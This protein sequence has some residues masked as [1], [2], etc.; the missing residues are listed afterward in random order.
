L[1]LG[2]P[3]GN[4][5]VYV[6]DEQQREVPLGVVGEICIGGAGVSRGYLHEGGVTAAQYVPDPFSASGGERLYRSGDQGRYLADGRL[7]FVG[8]GDGQVKVRGY[9]VELG[10]VE[11]ALRT[12]ESV[13]ESVVVARTETDAEQRLVAYLVGKPGQTLTNAEVRKS[14]GDKLPPYMIPSVFV[15]LDNLPLT[16]NGKVNRHA[17]P[18]P[19]PQR[20][21]SDEI[22]VTARN[23]IEETLASI[24]AELLRI[25]KVGIHDNFFELGGDSIISMQIVA[26]ANR[27]GLRLRPAQL[28]QYQTIA[29]LAAVAGDRST[30]LEQLPV[31][32]VV[33]LTPIQHWFFEQDLPNPHHWNQSVLL[34]VRQA[35]APSLLQRAVGHVLVH[36]DALRM[37]FHRGETGWKQINAPAVAEIPFSLVDLSK[38][39][40]EEQTAA[41]NAAA[42]EAQA[43]LNLVTGPLLRAVYF[44]LGPDRHGLLLLVIHHLVVDG[45]SWRILLEDLEL[46]YLQMSRGEM[47]SLSPKT[48]SFKT[49]ASQLTEPARGSNVEQQIDYWAT[50]SERQASDLPVDFHGQTNTQASAR[51]VTVALTVAETRALLHEVSVRHHTH[52]NEVLLAALVHSFSSFTENP[53]LLIDL[54]GH[55]R[56]ELVEGI[57]LSRTVGWFTAIYPVLLKL[58]QSS[59]PAKRLRAI[60]EQLRHIPDRGVSYGILRYLTKNGAARLGAS[61]PAQVSFNY[62][63]QLDQVFASSTLFD[64]LLESDSPSRS[65]DGLRRYLL[66]IIGSVIEGRLKLSWTYSENFH[67][68]ATIEKL[69]Q[70]FVDALR[71]IITSAT[72]AEVSQLTPADFPLAKLTQPQLAALLKKYENLEDVY[73]L[74]PMQQGLLF[75]S[76]YATDSGVYVEQLNCLLR[77]HLDLAAFER[78]WQRVVE[79]HPILRTAFFWE[80]LKAPLQVVT[81]DVALKIMTEDWRGLSTDEQEQR[82]NSFLRT[83]RALGFELQAPPLIRLKLHQIADDAHQFIWTHHHLLLDG[84]SLPIVLNEVF[85]LY[86]LFVQGL[87][88]KLKPSRPYS[89][90]INWLS[91]QDPAASETFWRKSLAGF[92]TPTPLV[93]D[94]AAAGPAELTDRYGEQRARLSPTT[95]NA[96]KA[97]GRSHHLTL[98]TLLQGA[99]AL[100]QHGYS[101]TADVVFGTAVSARPLTLPGAQEM[102]GIFFNTLPVRVQVPSSGSLLT[103]LQELQDKQSELRKHEHTPLIEIQ[104]W[105][106]VPRGLPLFESVLILCNYPI[107]DAFNEPNRNLR[108]EEIAWLEQTNYPLTMQVFPGAELQLKISYDRSRFEVS[109]IKRILDHFKTVLEAIG[110]TAELTI[111][112]IQILTAAEQE[113]ILRQ[114]NDT[115][116]VYAGRQCLHELFEEQVT[117]TPDTIA[118]SYEDQ[119]LTYAELNQRANKLAHHLRKLGV[120]SEVLV[121]VF[122]ERSLEMVVG[123]LGILKAGAA[124]LPLDPSYPPERLSFML[125]DAALSVLV[126]QQELADKLPAHWCYTI[127]LDTEWE[128]IEDEDAQNLS[129]LVTDENLAYVIYTSGSTGRPKGAMLNHRGVVNCVRWMQ[130]TYKLD[131][132]DRFLLKTSLNFDPSVWELFW[133]LATGGRLVVA[134]PG[135]H[136]SADYLVEVIR[137]EQVTSVYFVPSMLRVFVGAA[138]VEKIKSL[139]RVICG[140]ESLAKETMEGC[141]ARLSGVDLHHSYGPTEASIAASEWQCAPGLHEGAAPI[142]RP[143]S[144]TQIYLLDE[145]LR[146]VPVGVAGELYIGGLHVGRGY[147][148]RPELTA[149]RFIPDPFSREPGVRFYRTGDLARYLPD[150]KLEFLGRVDSQIKIRGYRIELG[151]IEAAVSAHPAVKAAVAIIRE[152][153][154]D[155]QLVVYVLPQDDADISAADV[156]SFLRAKLPDYMVPSWIVMVDDLPLMVNGKVDRRSLPALKTSEAEKEQATAGP[157]T[158]VEE[159]LRAIWSEVLERAEL[160]TTSNFF[161]L[162]G[163]SLLATQVMLRIKETF[164]VEMHLRSLFESPTVR[165]LALQIEAANNERRGWSLP[166]LARAKPNGE[167]PLSHAQQML[168]FADQL[169]PDSPFYNIVGGVRLS[170]DLDAVALERALSE[171]IRRHEILRTTFSQQRGTPVQVVAPAIDFTLPVIDLRK[172]TVLD[173]DRTVRE[174][175]L[176]E[177]RRPF[178]LS[179]GPLIRASLLRLEETEHVALFTMHHI[180]SDGWSLGVLMKEA[181]QLYAAYSTGAE[182]S[183]KELPLQYADYA[184]WQREWLTGAVLDQQLKYWQEQLAGVPKTLALAVDRPRPAIQSFNGQRQRFQL[185]PELSRQLKELS[186]QESSS[187]YM[188][189]LTAYQ[190]LLYYYSG[191]QQFTVG[192]P[193]AGRNQLATEDLIGVFLNTVVMRAE[194]SGNPSFRELLGR[195]REICLGAYANQDVPFAKVVEVLQPERDRGGSPLFQ[196]WFM[197]ADSPL[198][199]LRLGNL[200]LQELNFDAITAI[201]DLTLLVTNAETHLSGVLE[202]NSDLFDSSTINRMLQNFDRLLR[203]IVVEPDA[204]LNALVDLLRQADSEQRSLKAQGFKPADR[205]ALKSIKRKVIRG[206]MMS[207]RSLS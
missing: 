68:R 187:L 194:L 109:S 199:N 95:T 73:P 24:W 126:T 64:N 45:V 21:E 86:E 118:V 196:V 158:P 198:K 94:R 177:T 138:D 87:A 83:D 154:E 108:I 106:D 190:I 148:N 139:R 77:G 84:W 169:T 110:S 205:Q 1:P 89:H 43:S 179:S 29:Q 153:A 6:L 183:L 128:T 79:R 201:S 99:W 101:R 173:R 96:L 189:M 11:S 61:A 65:P 62:L 48:T 145:Y 140:G 191:Q 107:T 37:Y 57:D 182:S 103:W 72:S 168:W 76:M 186:R 127:C 60:K 34:V 41:L 121:G 55:G 180:V 172:S 163:H 36:H 59:S 80:G 135:G 74:A 53:F 98:H 5:R 17:L 113:Q 33:P 116:R 176:D 47:V 134:R 7:S 117:R 38:V 67:H 129:G 104:R 132:S 97:L 22:F 185:T 82:L 51:T 167:I 159:V 165:E 39:A 88:D 125:D 131:E 156:R 152:E 49:W 44:D 143:L 42:V 105:S 160:S 151:E 54:E 133:T 70:S 119:A 174:L 32:G 123:L 146:P 137:R 120:D 161:E 66:G 71:D 164:G 114:W 181:S 130:E 111:D 27:A 195:V 81:R 122:L 157:R 206:S 16:E 170:G 175:A 14:L 178:D 92:A 31:N 75:H 46:A 207:E 202:Y 93:F 136:L 197:L 15:F 90:Y 171:I 124:Y 2:R 150:G 91:Q 9:R 203:S 28:F 200:K 204:Q 192:T 18:A 52:I 50:V 58:K 147:L 30:Q 100:L 188:T 4:T 162:G 184:I 56:E 20:T 69:A 112:E 3:L 35:L 166:V 85:S 8:R 155:K 115:Q 144:N 149:E 26:R 19:E 141:F 142:G 25:E 13:K 23:P 40:H 102:V 12:I 78:A 193:V 10:E 63:G